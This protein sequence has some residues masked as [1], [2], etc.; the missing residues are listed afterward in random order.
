MTRGQ[1]E[2]PAVGAA[3]LEQIPLGRF[4]TPDEVATAVLYASTATGLT[5]SSLII[6]GGWTAK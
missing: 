5:G 3:L 6:D 1:L 2:D 4:L